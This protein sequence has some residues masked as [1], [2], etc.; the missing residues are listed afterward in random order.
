MTG[1]RGRVLLQAREPDYSMKVMILDDETLAREVLK[2]CIPWEKKKLTL[3]YE[4]DNA[5]DALEYLREHPVDII[6]TDIT[7][8]DMMNYVWL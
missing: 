5:A 8:P 4:G 1:K 2:Y 7:M 3:A 6:L